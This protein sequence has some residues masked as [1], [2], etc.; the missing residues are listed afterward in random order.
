MKSGSMPIPNMQEF[1]P[2]Y[3]V[4]SKIALISNVSNKIS[5]L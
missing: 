5:I 4:L 3:K 2:V 1:V